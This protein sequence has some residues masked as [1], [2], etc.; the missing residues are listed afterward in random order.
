[1]PEKQG[2]LAG[3]GTR[4]NQQSERCLQGR[5]EPVIPG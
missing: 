1:V 5:Q 3:L 4:L 2:T